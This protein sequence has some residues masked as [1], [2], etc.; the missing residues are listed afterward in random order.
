LS[1]RVLR[2][3]ATVLLASASLCAAAPAQAA[4]QQPDL[5]CSVGLRKVDDATTSAITVSVQC[6]QARTVSVRITANGVALASLRQTVQADLRQTVSITVPRVPQV[7]ATLG[8]NDQTLTL[9]APAAFR[10][11]PSA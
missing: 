1:H 10:L 4:A 7:C 5:P 9:C 3:V 2:S 6:Q 11:P 8:A